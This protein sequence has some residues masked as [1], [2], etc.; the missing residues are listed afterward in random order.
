MSQTADQ[1]RA[2][3]PVGKKTEGRPSEKRQEAADLIHEIL[4]NGPTQATLIF[5]QGGKLGFSRETMDRAKKELDVTVYREGGL[6]WWT[7][8]N[9]GRK[10]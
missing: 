7:L 8:E 9:D 2:D 10:S 1:W 4:M 3:H 5:E 6:Y